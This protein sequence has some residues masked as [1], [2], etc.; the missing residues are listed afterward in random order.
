MNERGN[1]LIEPQNPWKGYE[2]KIKN[3]RNLPEV[4]QF[5]RMCF[6]LFEANELGKKFMELVKER[7]LMPKLADPAHPQYENL[8]IFF[9]GFKD[10]WRCVVSAI[11]SH[12]QRIAS[13]DITE[14]KA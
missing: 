13:T 4:I 9:D 3:L 1:P 11:N 10:A 2:E 8:L 12:K 7:Y 6:E 14:N 5:D